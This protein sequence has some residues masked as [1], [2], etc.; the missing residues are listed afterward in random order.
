LA[1]GDGS[2]AGAGSLSGGAPFGVSPL[3]LP[4]KRREAEAGAAVCGEVTRTEALPEA[5]LVDRSDAANQ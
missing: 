4:E 2:G 3:Q 1:A 5:V